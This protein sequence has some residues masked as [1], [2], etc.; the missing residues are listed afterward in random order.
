MQAGAMVRLGQ[1]DRAVKLVD[2]HPGMH[3]RQGFLAIRAAEGLARA[4]RFDDARA[5]LPSTRPTG[6][7]AEESG[8]DVV[9]NL[10]SN[11]YNERD[12]SDGGGTTT[13]TIKERWQAAIDQVSQMISQA[14]KGIG[15]PAMVVQMMIA[16]L[17][18]ERAKIPTSEAELAER[19]GGLRN[20]MR[21]GIGLS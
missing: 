14:G 1:A 7:V 16:R 9:N 19:L 20:V 8:W 4:Q 15:L 6:D 18:E 17:G 2:M 5:M 11:T 3:D 21:Q 10:L 12:D 13:G